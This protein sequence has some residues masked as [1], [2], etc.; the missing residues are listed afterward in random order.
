MKRIFDNPGILIT[1]IMFIAAFSAGNY[2]S[3]QEK[4]SSAPAGK[5]AITIHIS[6][7][8]DGKIIK[9]D[10]TFEAGSDFDVDAFLDEKGI[11]MKQSRP[12]SDSD[13]EIFNFG[14]P[15]LD[16]RFAH[17]PDSLIND[18][19]MF[20]IQRRLEDLSENFPGCPGMRQDFGTE[21]PDESPCPRQLKRDQKRMD[22]P[23]CCPYDHEKLQGMFPPQFPGMEFAPFSGYG[24]PEKVIIHKKRHG[25]KVVITYNDDMESYMDGAMSNPGN[26]RCPAMEQHHRQYMKTRPGH[27]EQ[28]EMKVKKGKPARKGKQIIII[29]KKAEEDQE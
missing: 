14:F 24:H 1:L 6:K 11:G 12:D 28:M 7:D 18:S 17:F 29:E 26:F 19:L 23:G 13:F 25:K 27:R 22:M 15:E 5:S 3:A 21:A 4:E 16:E 2:A 20:R 9:F 10:T 8:D